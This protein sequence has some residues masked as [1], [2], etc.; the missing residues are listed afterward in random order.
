MPSA[1]V[2][3]ITPE[4]AQAYL[5]LNTQNRSLNARHLAALTDQ[6][7]KGQWLTTYEPIQFSHTNRL[8]NGQ[9]RLTAIL[10]SGTTQPLL[11]IRGLP[12]ESFRV[13][14]TGRVRTPGDLLGVEGH[15]SPKTL[16]AIVRL[17]INYE[18][19]QLANPRYSVNN[20]EVADFA[21]THQMHPYV[22]KAKD[23]YADS[24]RLLYSESEFGFFYYVLAKI[25]R[26]DAERFLSA[27]AS[28]EGLKKETPVFKL[29]KRLE[30]L[31]AGRQKSTLVEKLGL[32]FKAWNQY[33]RR[34]GDVP[35]SFHRD[36]ED[37]PAPV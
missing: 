28:G 24:N 18:R 31:R 12:D 6:M 34:V 27:L 25:D 26:Y 13:M 19:G 20:L 16:A 7:N 1:Q 8:L 17:I 11:V 35:L 37:V 29:R 5:K 4:I 10:K 14:D 3:A 21:A 9:H 30:Q 23:W 32:F 2:E 36:R 33:R 22:R 15:A